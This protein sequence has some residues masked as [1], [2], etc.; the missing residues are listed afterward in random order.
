[1]LK[2]FAAATLIA[3]SIFGCGEKEQKSSAAAAEVRFEDLIQ[4][5]GVVYRKGSEIPFT[6]KAVREYQDGRKTLTEFKD[7][8][9]N[10]SS[11]LWHPNGQKAMEVNL[12][13]NKPHGVMIKY[14]RNGDEISRVEYLNG[15]PVKPQ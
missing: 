13:D 10:G 9:G 3:V 2:V 15:D 1:M 7:G 12:V 8:R 14:D 4:E 5:N 6:G 11:V